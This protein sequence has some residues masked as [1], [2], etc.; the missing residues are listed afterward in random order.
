MVKKAKKYLIDSDILIAISI[1]SD[2]RN[3]PM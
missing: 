1:R 3:L 2:S